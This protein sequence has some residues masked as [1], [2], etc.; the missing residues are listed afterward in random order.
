MYRFIYYLVI[1]FYPCLLFATTSHENS[2]KQNKEL[3]AFP[4]AEGFGRLTT[5]GRGGEVYWVTTLEDGNHK[6]TLRHAVSQKGPRTILFNV[7][8]TI[9]LE[10]DLRITEGDITIAGQSAP[11]KGICIAGYPVNLS[12]DNIIIRYLRFRV[13]DLGEGEPDGFMG[14]DAKNI[15][16]DHCSISWSVDETCSIYGNENSTVQWCMITESLRQSDHSKGKHGYGAIWGGTRASFH[17]NLLAHHESRVPRLGPSVSTQ[18]NEHVDMRNN[19]FYNWAGG[20]CYG[21]EGMH[22]NIVNNYYKPGPATQNNKVK[23]RIV[24]I[25]IRTTEY[26]TG[27]NGRPNAWKPME[28]VWGRFYIDGNVIEG[29]SE[30]TQDNWTKGVYEQIDKEGNDSTFT[31]Q[32]K[33]E[34][35][36]TKPLESGIV[37]TH[38][39]Q[40]AYDLI[41]VQAGCSRFRDTIDARIIEEVKT[42]T[43]T[44]F[45]SRSTDAATFPGL[46]DS[47]EDVKPHGAIS[48]WPNLTSDK[49]GT[50][51]VT[52]SD[53]DGIPDDW[54]R[55]NNLNPFDKK[56]GN[57]T[58]LSREGYTNLEFYINSLVD[59]SFNKL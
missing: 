55:K 13:G 35:R 6:G 20:G 18:K 59:G 19:V 51:P 49:E 40:E 48:A 28:H 45:G 43:T 56:D 44:Y 22:V 50:A 7:A 23:Y 15:I 24:A 12:A 42:G 25:G 58:N 31:E 34:I 46:I 11:G 3:T 39:A 53:G 14:R 2:T 17:H 26:V 5:G 21:G 52:D 47:Q 41:L 38:S 37:T 27:R 16:I 9:F 54:E 36:L 1:L 32:I 10:K 30:V 4:G 29:N 33:K 8:G 57:R